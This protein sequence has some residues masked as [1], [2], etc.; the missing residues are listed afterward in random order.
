MLM[1]YGGFNWHRVEFTEEGVYK[2]CN[3]FHDHIYLS[4]YAGTIK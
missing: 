1:L 4:N 3:V 2:E